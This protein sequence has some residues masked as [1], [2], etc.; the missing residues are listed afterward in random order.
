VP[1]A[2]ALGILGYAGVRPVRMPSNLVALLPAG[3]ALDPQRAR[4]ASAPE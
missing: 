3:P 1:S 4:G 2:D